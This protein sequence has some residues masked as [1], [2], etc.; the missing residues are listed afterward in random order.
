M[1]TYD[2][3]GNIGDVYRMSSVA[4]PVQVANFE[5][6]PYGQLVVSS[7]DAD[8]HF[9]FRFSTKYLDQ[10]TGFYYYGYRYYS[11]ILGRWLSIDPIG[12][13]GDINLFQFNRNSPVVTYDADGRLSEMLVSKPKFIKDHKCTGKGGFEAS[14]AKEF[15]RWVLS[16]GEEQGYIVQKITRKRSNSN[17]DGTDFQHTEEIVWEAWRVERNVVKYWPDKTKWWDTKPYDKDQI[18]E[19]EDDDEKPNRKGYTTVE[20]EAGFF[21]TKDL[22][23]YYDWSLGNPPAHNLMTTR[24]EPRF[25]TG[26]TKQTSKTV[27]YVWKCCFVNK[28]KLY[29]IVGTDSGTLPE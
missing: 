16:S 9:P 15:T 3:N 13:W 4:P 2:G 24:R 12:E 25:W 21:A 19:Y 8:L 27:G 11:P 17:Y 20:F 26:M 29:W 18:E 7:I 22:L 10:E 1:P 6:D 5:Y 23:G 28:R 14:I